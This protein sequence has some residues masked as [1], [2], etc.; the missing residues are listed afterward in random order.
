VTN[1]NFRGKVGELEL[2][3]PETR[4]FGANP[5]RSAIFSTLSIQIMHIRLI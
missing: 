5:Q 1:L 4:R 2:P 3:L